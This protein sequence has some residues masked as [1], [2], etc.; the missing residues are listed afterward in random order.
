VLRHIIS[1][2]LGMGASEVKDR[3][4]SRGQLQPLVEPQL[5]QA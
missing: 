3:G 1:C 5:G 4:L 2:T